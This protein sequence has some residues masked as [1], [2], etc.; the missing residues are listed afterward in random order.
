MFEKKIKIMHSVFKFF[1]WR[2]SM[3]DRLIWKVSQTFVLGS[4][5]VSKLLHIFVFIKFSFLNFQRIVFLS[6]S[7]TSYSFLSFLSQS[8]FP[9]SMSVCR[10]LELR[11]TQHPPQ[12]RIKLSSNIEDTSSVFDWTT[13]EFA[14]YRLGSDMS[15]SQAVN[16]KRNVVILQRENEQK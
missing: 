8:G 3:T 2:K 11:N 6:N 14:V 1:G 5:I 13:S 7:R 9:G 10:M 15:S 12:R 16:R 4:F